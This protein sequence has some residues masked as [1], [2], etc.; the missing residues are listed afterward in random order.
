MFKIVPFE[1]VFTIYKGKFGRHQNLAPQSITEKPM[2]VYYLDKWF[3]I[4]P[5][6]LLA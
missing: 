2:E 3:V 4:T 5:Y 6:M 1:I